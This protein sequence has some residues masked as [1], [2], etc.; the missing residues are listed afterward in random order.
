MANS[1]VQFRVDEAT[2]AKA[3]RIC[4]KNNIDLQTFLQKCLKKVVQE[5]GVPFSIK[6]DDEPN[7]AAME[8]LKRISRLAEKTGVADMTLDEINAEIDAVRYGSG[9]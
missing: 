2:R 4:E 7:R 5:N 3:E 9:R 6:R 1:V 8:A